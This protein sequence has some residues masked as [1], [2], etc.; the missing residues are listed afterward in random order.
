LKNKDLLPTFSI[1]PGHLKEKNE[2]RDKL[3][4]E[5]FEL[6]KPEVKEDKDSIC[7]RHCGLDFKIEL[8]NFRITISNEKGILYQDRNG[9][10]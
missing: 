8:L 3:S 2:E 5:G 9:L 4:L 1:N 10:A 7:F 6:C